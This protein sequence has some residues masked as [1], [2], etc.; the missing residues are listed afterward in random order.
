MNLLVALDGKP[1]SQQIVDLVEQ[2]IDLVDQK[3][4]LLH[5]LEED[6]AE[7]DQT[8]KTRRELRTIATRE[9]EKLLL[10]LSTPL[11]DRG[12]D[13]ST[14]VEYGP[15][16]VL[17]K[18]KAEGDQA[19]II[20]CAP[21]THSAKELLL[22][23]SLTRELMRFNWE[24]TLISARKSKTKLGPIVF[25]LDGT[26]E[27][28]D[29]LQTN[30]PYLRKD[31]PLLLLASQIGYE[32]Q[33]NRTWLSGSVT[34]SPEQVLDKAS[35]ILTKLERKHETKL[36]DQSFEQ[37]L[38]ESEAH[39]LFLSR[40]MSDTTHQA[41]ANSPAEALFLNAHCSTALSCVRSNN[42]S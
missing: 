32:A 36:T 6:R 39:L 24:G 12:A 19:D 28:Y 30:L 23:G 34:S 40:T 33:H 20:V 14:E 7:Q 41:I 10:F 16:Q 13:V 27:S 25:I 15:V 5:I 4:T 18:S 29:C 3:V 42:F 35:S 37:W 11:A 21:G 9:A 38:A 31:S 1:H 22:K 17:V 2:T 26:K 8:D